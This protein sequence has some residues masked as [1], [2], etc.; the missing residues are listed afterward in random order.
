M[1]VTEVAQLVLD[2]FASCELIGLL[3]V[4]DPTLNEAGA[5][6]IAREIH[7]RR[8]G[9]GEQ[10]VGRKIGWT[11]RT[12][13]PRFNV[14]APIWGYMYDSTVQYASDSYAR[15]PVGHLLQP[16]IEPEIQLHFARTPPVTRDEEAILD[17]IDWIAHGFELVQCPFPDWKFETVAACGLHGALVIGPPVAVTDIGDCAAKLRAFQITLSKSG[18]DQVTGGGANVLD[19]PL[20]AF[21][22]L[23]EVLVSQP[24]ATPVQAGEVVTTGTLTVPIP[25]APGDR[26]SVT[27]DGI[28]LGHRTAPRLPRNPRIAGERLSS[29][30]C[31]CRELSRSAMRCA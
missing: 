18:E 13:W 9:R 29:A 4:A 10:P 30:R 27:L 1:L 19:S 5:Y 24:Q 25:V 2:A 26:F 8:I 16:Q 17:C 31:A 21:A 23:A 11:N 22:H 7:E 3:S 12:I 15:I 28:D 20:L 14:R 6:A